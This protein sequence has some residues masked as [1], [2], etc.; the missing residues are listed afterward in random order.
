[1]KRNIAAFLLIIAL[2]ITAFPLP[3]SAAKSFPD[4]PESHWGYAYVTALTDKGLITG[5][6]DGS[7]G[8]SRNITRAELVTIVIKSAVGTQTNG[9]MHWAENYMLKAVDSGLILAGDFPSTTWDTPILRQEI[10]MVASRAMEF[11]MDEPP[12]QDTGKLTAKI[13]DWGATLDHYKP[14][15]AQ[16]YAKGIV[17]GY[18]DGSFGGN[19]TATRAEAATMLTRLF[20]KAY[21]IEFIGGVAFSRKT[22]ILPNGMMSVAKS[23]EYLDII[24]DNLC[25]YGENGKY[26]VKC[27]YPELPEGFEPFLAV[28]WYSTNGGDIYTTNP[29]RPE[30]RIPKVGE[31]T[32]EITRILSPS[33]ITYL[34]INISIDTIGAK[35]DD[36]TSVYYTIIYEYKDKFSVENK[37]GKSYWKQYDFSKLFT[38]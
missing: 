22:D 37:F 15:I 28:D 21:R 9:D 38:W 19:K 8:P 14:H 6:N 1:M 7:F 36:L 3:A 31:F 24:F 4:V 10:A 29:I 18:P 26:Y 23:I 13:T 32:R 2:T 17:G 20:D 11:L 5:Y 34:S 12:V 25:F 35:Y 30:T 33:N 27:S 16:V